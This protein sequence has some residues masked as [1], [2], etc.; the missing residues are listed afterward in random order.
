METNAHYTIVGIFVITLISAIV[1]AIIWLS[2]G[3]SFKHYTNYL[4]YM[5]ESVTG[6]NIDAPVEYNGVSVGAVKMINLYPK[7]PKFVQLLLSIEKNTPITQGTV[8]TLSTRGVTGV[9]F[10]AL[11]E[12]NTNRQPLTHT[13]GQPYPVIKTAPSLFVRLDTALSQLTTSFAKISDAMQG[14]LDKEN[15]QTI[16]A[17]LTN[18]ETVTGTLS[19]NSK[20]LSVI[21]NNTSRATQQFGP[22]MQSSTGAMRMLETQTLP[23][24][25]RLMSNLDDVTRTLSAVS[26]EIKQNP[27]VLLR[28]AA[29]PSL[30]PG[31]K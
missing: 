13:P 18:L 20:Q 10:I 19:A 12:N 24:A 31:E 27:S 15:L 17:T 3:F 21:L 14:L 26:A 1:L 29:K 16:K 2:S 5:Q 30:G 28:G 8:A 9:T 25:Y 4:V 6:L 11:K 22:L 7:N 23:A